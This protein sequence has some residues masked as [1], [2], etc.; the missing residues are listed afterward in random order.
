M[1]TT[2]SV[3]VNP[4]ERIARVLLGLLG[5]VGGAMLHTGAGSSVAVVLELL[6]ILAMPGSHRR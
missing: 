4:R 1:R 3:N 6:L 5:V 2:W